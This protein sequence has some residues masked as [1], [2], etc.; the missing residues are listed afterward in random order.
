MKTVNIIKRAE[1][2]QP[3]RP[4]HLL[5]TTQPKTRGL[6]PH[7][8]PLLRKRL[9]QWSGWPLLAWPAAIGV[10]LLLFFQSGP[11]LR[12]L[13]PTAAVLDA[14]LISVLLFALL[15]TLVFGLAANL[16]LRLA[17]PSIARCRHELSDQT[18]QRLSPCQKICV[19]AGSYLGCLFAFVGVFTAVL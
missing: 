16:L 5:H 3:P 12:L 4:A 1:L 18:F 17:A 9:T 11:L 7:Q 19:C 13:D 6:R 2:P 15:A 14:G 8:L 10:T